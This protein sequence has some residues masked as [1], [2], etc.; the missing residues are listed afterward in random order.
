MA[1]TTII[2][3]V[4]ILAIIVGATILVLPDKKNLTVDV[5]YF[6]SDRNELNIKGFSTVDDNE[7]IEYIQ[8]LI[9]YYNNL[10]ED[11]D[12]MLTSAT[13]L[14]FKASL[15]SLGQ[16]SRVNSKTQVKWITDLIPTKPFESWMQPVTFTATVSAETVG[17]RN[18]VGPYSEAV[19]LKIE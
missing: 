1:K 10:P 9:I 14:A 13:P 17:E 3:I 19:T 15:F 16:T 5:K 8:F 7:E 11:L 4:L 2:A 6:D 12:I 18:K